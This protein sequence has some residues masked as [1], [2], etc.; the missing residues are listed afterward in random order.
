M[1]PPVAAVA[2]YELALLVRS[3]RWLPPV[4]LL[5]FVLVTATA[6]GPPAG[7]A[8]AFG[9]AALVP[10]CAW[11]TRVVL[12]GDPPAARAC[13]MA[14]VGA[15]RTQAGCLAA[16]VVAAGAVCVVAT[17]ALTALVT[18]GQGGG[19]PGW[20]AATAASGLVTEL[21]CGFIGVALGAVGNPPVL[22]RVDAA[23]LV[24]G[25]GVTLA[26]VSSGSPAYA[27]I[28]DL[29][30]TPRAVAGPVA[31]QPLLVATVVLLL[32]AALSIRT[33]VRRGVR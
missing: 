17:V 16:A 20:V 22:R 8:L 7:D 9:G 25:L 26:L 33:A 28:S 21:A 4:V 5:G 29:S 11:L 27:A 2:R 15:A 31:W 13:L 6:G 3:Q 12:V 30:R 23:V 32:A 1:S 24:M 10:V 18:V 14:A 19:E